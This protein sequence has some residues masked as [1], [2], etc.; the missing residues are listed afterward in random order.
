MCEQI[1]SV[2]YK[3]L[4]RTAVPEDINT[5]KTDSSLEYIVFHYCHNI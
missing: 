4:G 2:R 1:S 3:L 5:D